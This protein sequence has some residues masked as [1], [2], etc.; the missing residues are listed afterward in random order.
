MKL[1]DPKPAAKAVTTEPLRDYTGDERWT[2][3]QRVIED[4][5]F[6]R[7]P[8]LREL[9]L[10]VTERAISGRKEEVNEHEIARAVFGRSDTFHSA[11]DS[12]VRSSARQLRTK[13]HEY[14]EGPG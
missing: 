4:E 8:R 13:L 2:L 9:L 3:L 5:S 12:I 10:F 6:R 1:N 7:A 11:D 14:F